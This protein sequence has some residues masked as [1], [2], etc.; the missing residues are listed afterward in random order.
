MFGHTANVEGQV[1]QGE[2]TLEV[3]LYSSYRNVFGPFHWA[4]SPEPLSVSPDLF[5]GYGTWRE[6]G[7]SDRYDSR[8]AFTRFGLDRVEIG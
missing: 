3:T 6:D 5:S 7:T 4:A 1:K 2:N 8:Y